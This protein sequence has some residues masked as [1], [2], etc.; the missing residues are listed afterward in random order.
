MPS[1]VRRRKIWTT[2]LPG[3]VRIIFLHIHQADFFKT[4][5]MVYFLKA[6]DLLAGIGHFPA[7]SHLRWRCI[8]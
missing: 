5:S 7:Y 1:R 2:T 6:N 3:W 8:A 4:Y